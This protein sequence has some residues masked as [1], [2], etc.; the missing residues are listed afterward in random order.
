LRPDGVRIEWQIGTPPSQDLPFLCY[1]VTPREL[2][3]PGDEARNHSNGVTGIADLT[4]SVASLAESATR[5]TALLGAGSM[6]PMSIWD[7]S[8]LPTQAAFKVGETDIILM[9]NKETDRTHEG[10]IALSFFRRDASPMAL[11]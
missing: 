8:G 10:P 3:V 1:D 5:Y 4:I 9:Q 6:V 7:D 11:A 2:R